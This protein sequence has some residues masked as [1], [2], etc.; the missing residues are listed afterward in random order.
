M[1][2]GNTVEEIEGRRVA[3]I[4]GD[5]ALRIQWCPHAD[6]VMFAHLVKYRISPRTAGLDGLDDLLPSLN[7][8]FGHSQLFM[9]YVLPKIKLALKWRLRKLMDL[10]Y[11]KKVRGDFV[12]YPR[13]MERWLEADWDGDT[14]RRAE[15]NPEDWMD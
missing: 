5:T 12:K 3:D 7:C 15:D 1:C 13:W 2:Q 8:D 6:Q 14:K 4:V 9:I 11:V 10:K